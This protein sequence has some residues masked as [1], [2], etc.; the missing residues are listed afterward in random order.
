MRP[1]PRTVATETGTCDPIA[2][3]AVLGALASPW[4]V[5]IVRALAEEGELDV[6]QIAERLDQPVANV[7]AHL[8]RL[9]HAGIVTSRRSGTHIHNRLAPGDAT[10]LCAQACAVASGSPR[11]RT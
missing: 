11:S 1:E 8:E 3:A 4:R 9:R 6:G 7:S 5:R 10:A 2:V